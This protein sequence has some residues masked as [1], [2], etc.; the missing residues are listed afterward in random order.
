M[1]Y[2]GLYYS[3]D[4]QFKETSDFD[5]SVFNSGT[6][7]YEV[8]RI[9]DGTAL[10]LE[11]HLQ[12]LQDSVNLAGNN[13]NV[14][15]PVIHYLLRNLIRRNNTANGNVRILVHFTGEKLPV[16]YTF[17]TPHFYPGSELYQKGAASALYRTERMDPNIKKMHPELI[18][19]INEFIKS[20]KIYDAILI[21]KD[22]KITEGSRTNVFFIHG[23]S[24][25]TAPSEKVLIGITRTKVFQLCKQLDINLIEQ[26]ISSTTLNNFDSA[27]FSGTSPKILPINYIDDIQFSVENKLTLKIMQAYDK[28]V[29]DYVNNN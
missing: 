10:F 17:F 5:Q 19:N 11:D 14:S 12:R 2:T 25:I 26:D 22:D 24:L 6:V 20:K 23:D 16:I 4:I 9:I 1:D 13:F 21:D 15:V 8:L 7:F 28:L 27:F 18:K 3:E 29:S